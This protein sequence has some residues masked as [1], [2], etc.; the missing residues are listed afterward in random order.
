M[1]VKELTKSM[2]KNAKKN[3]RGSGLFKVSHWS[4]TKIIHDFVAA[5][6]FS[7]YL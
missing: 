2:R 7:L 3:L 6:S 1:A 4:F 5:C